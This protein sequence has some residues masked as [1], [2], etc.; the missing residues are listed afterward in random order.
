MLFKDPNFSMGPNNT[1]KY[2]NSGA[3]NVT[4]T[5]ATK[6]SD[7]PITGTN[8]EMVCTNIGSASPGLGG[9]Y[10]SHQSRK[11]AVF[12]YRIIAKIPTGHNIQFASNAVGDDTRG[13][14]TSNAGTGKFTEYV[15][16][17]ICGSTGTFSTTGYFYI[18]GTVGTSSAPVTWYIAYATAFD[19]SAKSEVNNYITYINA[20]N[21]I[22]VH[23]S[24]DTTDFVQINS[25]AINF[26]RNNITTLK[27]E[28]AKIT[29]GRL[30]TDRRNVYITDSAVQIR[31]NETVLTE[32]GDSIKMYNPSTNTSALEISSNGILIGER[33]G[34]NVS[35]TDD[36][37]E[38]S[39][40]GN[41]LIRLIIND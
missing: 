14:L 4:W 30:G 12:L 9:F 3:S 6:S 22:K 13:W 29:V 11:N 15:F 41:P 39:V 20:S 16:K 25:S 40:A 5:R 31:N 32:Y 38:I 19:M 1:T 24:D 8:Y 33:E 18:D 36:D 35:I 10:W 7:N 21:G 37:I 2:A 26:C 17:L 27:I 23:S 34:S 28:D